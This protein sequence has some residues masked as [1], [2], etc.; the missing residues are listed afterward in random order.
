MLTQ[1]PPRFDDIRA[2]Y[3]V[4]QVQWGCAVKTP[5]DEGRQ[6]ESDPFWNT[7]PV[8]FPE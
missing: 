5:E 4:G 6:L 1:T 3:A 7:K 2:I 8:E